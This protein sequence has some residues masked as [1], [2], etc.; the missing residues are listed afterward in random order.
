MLFDAK[1]AVDVAITVDR[2]AGRY[3]P[4]PSTLK[5]TFP[6]SVNMDSIAQDDFT[7]SDRCDAGNVSIDKVTATKSVLSMVLA[8]TNHCVNSEKM[9]IGLKFKKIEPSNDETKFSGKV[10]YEYAFD[11]VPV[12]VLASLGGQND[13]YLPG[14]YTFTAAPANV[15]Y[16]FSDDVDLESV[17]ASDFSVLSTGGTD[18][19]DMPTIGALVK[20]TTN[21]T[22]TLALDGADCDE[23]QS[24]RIRLAA[25]SVGDSTKNGATGAAAPNLAPV[26]N[27]DIDAMIFSA[28]PT[29]VSVGDGATT[30]SG[31]YPA[32]TDIEIVVEFSSAVTV[33]GNPRLRLNL[34]GTRYATYDSGSGS[35]SLT[36]VYTAVAGVNAADL[37]YLATGSLT[38]NGGTIMLTSVPSVAATL[39]LPT[40]GATGSLGNLRN[41]VI[42]AT[43]PTVVS[44]VPSG[45]SYIWGAGTFDVSFTMSEAIDPA[46]IDDADLTVTPTTCVDVPTV[47]GAAVGGTGNKVIT[48][49]LSTNTCADAEAYTLEFDPADASDVPGNPGTGTVRSITVTTELAKPTILVSAPS[50]TRVNSSASLTYTV[51]YSGASA[52]T[53]ADGDLTIGGASADCTAVVSGSGLTTRTIT[54]SDCSADGDVQLEI[55]ADTATTVYG[56]LAD[57]VAEGDITDFTADNTPLTTPTESFP[58]VGANKLYTRSTDANFTLTFTGDVLGTQSALT[59]AFDLNCD[60]GGGANPV[61]F[62]LAR[63]SAEIVTI[64]PNEG[65]PDFVYGSNCEIAGDDVPDAAGNESDFSAIQFKVSDIPTAGAGPAATVSLATATGNGELDAVVFNVAMDTSTVTDSNVTLVCNGMSVL[66]SAL[67]PSNG[68]KTIAIDFDESDANWTALAGGESCDLTFTTD[69]MNSLGQ[70]LAAPA[71]FSFTT[72]P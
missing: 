22:V 41:I 62:S 54:M 63:T 23:E 38:L 46:E 55:A 10:S 57:A 17:T 14:D 27:F 48:F 67:T 66:I 71:V 29:V 15:K 7:I 25:L 47:T 34:A 60:T 65:S 13:I 6:D 11:N 53:L 26:I 16:A 28:P 21:H 58:T 69:V 64:T 30:A 68:D 4:M 72:A 24:F 61:G 2:K 45:A 49:S 36:F 19:D 59:P 20:D 52:V 39:T 8:G 56:N 35:D 37:D 9:T 18:C 40:P 33:T 42:D 50:K 1:T 3:N 32:G 5:L 12:A 70:P 44:A 31:T 51:T 43:G